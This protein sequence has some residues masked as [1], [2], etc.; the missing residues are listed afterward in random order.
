MTPIDRALLSITKMFLATMKLMPT[1]GEV[2]YA[3]LNK[4]WERQN[5]LSL[6][7]FWDNTKRRQRELQ[8]QID[9]L[10]HVIWARELRRGK[11]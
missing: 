5:W 2:L 8:R 4:P 9:D 6:R 7:T 3:A 10:E 1:R 11:A